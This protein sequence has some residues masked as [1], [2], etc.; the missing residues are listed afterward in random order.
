MSDRFQC[1]HPTH[2]EIIILSADLFWFAFD[3]RFEI[4][5]NNIISI[6]KKIE[7]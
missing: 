4:I 1:I 7:L 6:L 2:P 5:S 3:Q